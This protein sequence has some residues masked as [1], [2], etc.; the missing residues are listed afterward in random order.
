MDDISA[1]DACVNLCTHCIICGEIIPLEGSCS[2]IV[3]R[4]CDE[5]KEAIIYLKQDYALRAIR[6]SIETGDCIIFPDKEE[7]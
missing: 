7:D 2:P 5:C 4:V 1:T 3:P 6:H